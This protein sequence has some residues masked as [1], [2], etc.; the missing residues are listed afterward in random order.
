MAQE[1]HDAL[2]IRCPQLGGPVTFGYCRRMNPVPSAAEGDDLPCRNLLGCWS[3]RFEVLPFLR[4]NYTPEQLEKAF[5]PPR[6]LLRGIQRL[7]E[8]AE[9]ARERA[10]PESNSRPTCP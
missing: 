5:A 7:I 9:R 4:E 6:R 8:L 10:D 3:G 2:E 1:T